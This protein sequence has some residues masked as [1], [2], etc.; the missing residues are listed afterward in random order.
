MAAVLDL[1]TSLGG[2]YA[3][4]LLSDAGLSVTRVEPPAG[5]WLRRWSASGA[6]MPDGGDG[7]LFRWLS[8]GQASVPAGR[9]RAALAAADAVLWSPGS[10]LDLD[11]VRE[12]ASVV[13]TVSPFGLDG[14]WADRPATE[15]TLQAMSG[16]PALRGSRA[17]APVTAGGQHGEYMAGVMAAVATQLALRQ[18][19]LGGPGGLVDVSALESLVMTQLFNPLTMETM[20]AGVRPRRPVATVG[21]VV[22][23]SDG[24][25]GFAVVNRLQHWLD[26][27]TMIGREDW[28]DDPTLHAVV[29]RTNRSAELNPVIWAWAAQRTTA[30]IVELAALWR[31][32]AIE[33]GNGAS[34]PRMEQFA[35]YGFYE[36]NPDGGFLQPTAPFRFHPEIA[37]HH[38]PPPAPTSQVAGGLPLAGVRVADFTSFW[39]GPFLAHTMAMFGADVIHVESTSR[40]DGARLMNWHPPTEPQWWEWSSYFQATNTNKRSVTIDL[41]DDEGRELARRL[42]AECDVVVENYSPRV[43]DG[44]GLGWDDVRAVRPDALMV[45]MPAFGLGGPWRDRTG[46]AMTME[47][48]SG[49]AWISGPPEHPP[50]ALFGP[51]DPSAGL[52]ALVGLLAALED[53]RRTGHGRLVE[54]PMV[55]G[56]LYVC[57]EQVIEHSAYGELLSRSGNRGPAAAPQ[58]CYASADDDPDLGQHRWVAIAVASDEQWVALRDVL[59]QPSWSVGV[60]TSAARQAAGDAIDEGLAAWCA[61]RGADEIV[62]ALVAAGVPAAVVVH[63]SAQLGFEQLHARRFLEEVEHPLCGASTHVTFPFRLPGQDEAMHRCPAPLLGE[64]N[65]QVFGGL[66]GLGDDELDA[67][68]AAGVIGDAP[69]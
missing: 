32:P 29:N 17:W 69:R 3:A 13:V 67:L 43:M 26:F 35:Q 40:L 5:H 60:E 42:I 22:P 28:A 9:H 41:A 62:D 56:A 57:A 19:A 38:A 18:V 36:T 64:H 12:A 47:Q 30:E 44:F 61:S 66:L 11:A 52:H 1:T 53:R 31:V 6:S 8:H 15:L 7:A 46:F 21:D 58:G 4:R 2:A 20:V 50:G 51:C 45:R 48:V 54:V 37:V 63:P 27:C 34:I 39:A 25:V 49:M 10:P 23:T 16:G 33:V 65:A 55:G 59:G 24:F 14:P 68:R